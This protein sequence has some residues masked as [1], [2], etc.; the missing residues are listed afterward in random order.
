MSQA[1]LEDHVV[2][3]FAC[4]ATAVLS[5]LREESENLSFLRRIDVGEK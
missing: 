3:G 4:D 5:G 1:E 2:F